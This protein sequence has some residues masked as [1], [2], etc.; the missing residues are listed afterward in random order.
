MKYH[1]IG[2]CAECGRRLVLRAD[3][4]MRIHRPRPRGGL[5]AD[6]TGSRKPPAAAA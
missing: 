4:L 1:G 3:G 2:T 5:I 6:C